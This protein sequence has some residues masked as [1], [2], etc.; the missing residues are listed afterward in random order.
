MCVIRSADINEMSEV[1]DMLYISYLEY[2]C[3]KS[4]L[5]DKDYFRKKIES[6]PC[7]DP[8]LSRIIKVD[9][10]IVSH[11][12]IYDRKMFFKGGILHVG[13]IGNVATHPQYRG[14]GYARMLLEDCTGYMQI[15]G[16][17]VSLLFG[18]PAIYG[19][20]GWE[21]LNS[22]GISTNL[23]LEKRYNVSTRPVNF[24]KDLI[25]IRSIYD[26]CNMLLNGPFLREKSYWEKWIINGMLRE[27]QSYEIFVVEK[28]N[29]VIGYY[30]TVNRTCVC[31]IGW[32][33]DNKDNLYILIDA[34]YSDIDSE[35]IMFN[36]FMQQLFDYISKNFAPP[37]LD[38]VKRQE[39]WIK[40]KVLYNGL[41][42]LISNKNETLKNIEN[43][44]ALNRLLIK[45]NYV[46]WPLDRF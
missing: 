15:R 4:S 41:F 42:K 30:A 19:K 11:I 13:A 40:K 45:N 34:I 18:E 1:Y 28:K 17:D 12:R 24:K 10:K 6:N 27:K 3:K 43:A 38:D 32:V 21:V 39:Y 23:R 20:S 35:I 8:G 5:K 22:F 14:R 2:A 46:F 36:F 33:P 44:S 25:A 31:E 37:S 16:F 29:A 9:G 26:K 7:F